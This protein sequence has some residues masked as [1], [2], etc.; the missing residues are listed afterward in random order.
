M[1]KFSI[2][3]ILL[4]ATFSLSAQTV[5]VGSW[6]DGELPTKF[7]EKSWDFSQY[8][9]SVVT[10]PGIYNLVFTFKSGAR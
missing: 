4:L 2:L 5:Q 10:K 1:K 6:A 8:I 3:I 9:S 7:E